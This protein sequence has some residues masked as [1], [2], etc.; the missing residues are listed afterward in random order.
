MSQREMSV[1][2]A[3]MGGTY[4]S[5]SRPAMTAMNT[6]ATATPIMGW[7]SP[8]NRS[9]Q[10][11]ESLGGGRSDEARMSPP[12]PA[13]SNR[14]AMKPRPTAAVRLGTSRFAIQSP[15]LGCAFGFVDLAAVLP[16]AALLVALELPIVDAFHD[17]PW[18]AVAPAAAPA[19]FGST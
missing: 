19:A 3:R 2:G 4:C 16:D 15:G 7:I 12:T 8:L 18:D 6:V 1:A 10:A 13:T 5:I 14:L 11:F 9:T 17:A